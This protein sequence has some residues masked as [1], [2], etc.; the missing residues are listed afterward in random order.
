MRADLYIQV[1]DDHM[2]FF[3]DL[4]ECHTFMQ[5]MMHHAI[6]QERVKWLE[7][8]DI[9]LLDWPGNSPDLNPVKNCWCHM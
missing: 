9:Q 2:L 8:C 4:H 7:E 6:R 1:L 3:H 5:V